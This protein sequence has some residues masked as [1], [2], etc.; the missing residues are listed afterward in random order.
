MNDTQRQT[1]LAHLRDSLK[2]AY[3]QALDADTRLDA[4]ASEN[5]AQFESVLKTGSGFTVEAVRFKPYVEEL[6]QDLVALEASEAFAADLEPLA[7][8]LAL[9]LQTL[10]RFKATA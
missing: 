1:V 4:L 8:K 10:A 2:A 3:Q 6:G 7:R 9:L 5:L